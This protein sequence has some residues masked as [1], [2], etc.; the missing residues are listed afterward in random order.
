VSVLTAE[1]IK[2]TGAVNIGDV[3]TT[4]PALA[5]SFTMGNSGRFIGTAGISMQDLR[6]LGTQRTLVLV[7]GRRIADFPMPFKG[8]SNFTD[9]SNIPLGMVERIEILTGSASAIYG[10]DA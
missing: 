1:D 9:I 8:R 10:S 7:N 6:N 5:T 4:M 3:L 2:A